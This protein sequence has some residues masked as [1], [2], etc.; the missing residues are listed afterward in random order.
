MRTRLGLGVLLV[1]V[2]ALALGGWTALAQT[3]SVGPTADPLPGSQ[4]QGG[5]GDQDNA[6]G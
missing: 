1:V 5:D 4:F 6:A 2:C 3:I